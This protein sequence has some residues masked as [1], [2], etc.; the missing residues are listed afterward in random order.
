[1]KT[2][3]VIAALFLA[4]L[5]TVSAGNIPTAAAQ[6][7][8]EGAKDQILVEPGRQLRVT[9]G[10]GQDQLTV[11]WDAVAEAKFYAV[12]GLPTRTTW[13]PRLRARTGST[14]SPTGE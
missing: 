8:A 10:P 5:V 14:S 13:R 6:D 3:I 4:I 11:S 1:M 9:Q 2:P 7:D 12:A